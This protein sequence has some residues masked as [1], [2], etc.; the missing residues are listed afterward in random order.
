MVKFHF[1]TFFFR[2]FCRDKH[3]FTHAPQNLFLCNNEKEQ[4]NEWILKWYKDDDESKFVSRCSTHIRRLDSLHFLLV[5]SSLHSYFSFSFSFHFIW[6]HFL[7]NCFHLRFLWIMIKVCFHG[8]RALKGAP[9]FLLFVLPCARTFTTMLEPHCFA[10]LLPLDV[11]VCVCVCVFFCPLCSVYF[12]QLDFRNF[13]L[14]AV[15]MCCFG[16]SNPLP[17]SHFRIRIH[18]RLR[19]HTSLAMMLFIIFIFTYIHFGLAIRV[20]F[21]IIHMK[22][23]SRKCC[24]CVSQCISRAALYCFLFSTSVLDF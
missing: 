18:T 4:I 10:V 2:I 14:C 3:V 20:G 13:E 23:H 17:Y 12:V 19:A 7:D 22:R 11:R 16:S 6:V 21:L 9:L 24:V 1:R 5:I 15:C 8:R